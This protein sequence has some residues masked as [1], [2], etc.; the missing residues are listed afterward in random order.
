MKTYKH[1]SKSEVSFAITFILSFNPHKTGTDKGRGG[2]N[3][4]ECGHG[5][6]VGRERE[7][8]QVRRRKKSI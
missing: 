3:C 6:E 4:L 5:L 1:N 8:R 2:L 7:Q